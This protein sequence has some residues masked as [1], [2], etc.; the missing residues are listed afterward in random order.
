MAIFPE[1]MHQLNPVLSK[2]SAIDYGREWAYDFDQNKFILQNGTPLIV[3]GLE[4]LKIYIIKTL[5][6]AR[7]R[8]LIHS[9]EYGCEIEDVLGKTLHKDV[10]ES[11]IKNMITEALIYDERI[12]AVT[13]FI[14]INAGDRVN[15]SFVVKTNLGEELE[16]NTNV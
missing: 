13:D 16:V 6:T 14:I 10:L 3:T 12:Y 4:A 8:Y 1:H 11:V 9:W 2:A 5:K 7:Y 15:V